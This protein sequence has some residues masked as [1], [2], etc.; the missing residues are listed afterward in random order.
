VYRLVAGVYQVYPPIPQPLRCFP[1]R[2]VIR[3]MCSHSHRSHSPRF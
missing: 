1:Y 2:P 3:Y